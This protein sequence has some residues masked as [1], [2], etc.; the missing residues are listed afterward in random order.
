[1]CS[2]AMGRGRGAAAAFCLRGVGSDVA[3]KA[4]GP[5][6][7]TGTTRGTERIG[8]PFYTSSPVYYTDPGDLSANGVACAGGRDGAAAA[9]TWNVPT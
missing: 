5:R 8:I 6:F 4:G 1:M 2:D 7:V 9:S 3:A